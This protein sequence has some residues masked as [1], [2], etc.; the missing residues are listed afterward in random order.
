VEANQL[1]RELGQHETAVYTFFR[2]MGRQPADAADLTQDTFVRALVG[3]DRFRFEASYRTWL[4]GIA[5]NVHREWVRRSYRSPDLGSEI[6]VVAL[7]DA[8]DTVAVADALGRLPLDERELL[9]LHHVEGLPSKEIAALLGISDAAAR[10]RLSRA[11]TSFRDL[12][13]ER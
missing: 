10:Q 2:R 6:D 4:L 12:W 3:A 5:R 1:A 7:G 13:G 9:V 11:A 8:D